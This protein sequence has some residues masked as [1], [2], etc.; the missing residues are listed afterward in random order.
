MRA[1][2]RWTISGTT[3]AE[4][5]APPHATVPLVV[6]TLQRFL[7]LHFENHSSRREVESGAPLLLTCPDPRTRMA[8][9]DARLEALIESL[10]KIGA[11]KFGTFTLKSGASLTIAS[12]HSVLQA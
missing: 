3:P 5:R 8:A 1:S 11:V 4:R 7:H 2:N 12:L 9:D 10:M 6:Y